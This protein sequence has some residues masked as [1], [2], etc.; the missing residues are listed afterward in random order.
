MV[1]IQAQ[2]ESKVNDVTHAMCEVLDTMVAEML[3]T[4]EESEPIIKIISH[5]AVVQG[6][7]I[8]I[9]HDCMEVPAIAQMTGEFERN[10]QKN[11]DIFLRVASVPAAQKVA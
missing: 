10:Q 1:I 9:Y 3:L 2:V 7:I 5:I 11:K 4:T 8:R 6:H